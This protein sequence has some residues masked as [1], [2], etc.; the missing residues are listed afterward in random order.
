MQMIEMWDSRITEELFGNFGA[1]VEG[2]NESEFQV[3]DFFVVIVVIVV[4]VVY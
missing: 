4:D 3:I 1:I 2:V